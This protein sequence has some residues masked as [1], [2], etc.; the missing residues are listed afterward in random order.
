MESPGSSRHSEVTPK[1]LIF[2]SLEFMSLTQCKRRLLLCQKGGFLEETR[3]GVGGPGENEFL[4][5]YSL[6]EGSNI[7][8]GGNS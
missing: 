1:Q 5:L 4:L 3:E 8:N 7:G 6:G 2:G